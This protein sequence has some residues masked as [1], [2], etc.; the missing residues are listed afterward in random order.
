[1]REEIARARRDGTPLSYV[2]IDL[3]DFKRVNDVGGH[4]AG[5]E[6]LRQVAALLQ[7]ELRPYDQVARYGGDELVLLLPGSDETA[8]RQIAERVRDAMAGSLVGACS[9]GVAEWHEPLDAD[10]LLDLLGHDRLQ[11]PD[12]AHGVRMPAAPASRAPGRC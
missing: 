11:V 7:Q 5:D 4:Q 1:V 9:L 6:L 12:R 2:I 10:A 8:A 3:D